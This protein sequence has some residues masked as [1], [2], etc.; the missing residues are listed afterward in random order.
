[1]K[2]E[3]ITVPMAKATEMSAYIN[4]ES[5][6]NF[7]HRLLKY[8]LAI[9]A[10]AGVVFISQLDVFHHDNTDMPGKITNSTTIQPELPILQSKAASGKITCNSVIAPSHDY[11]NYDPIQDLGW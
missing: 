1:M 3:Q 4:S 9:A 7:L 8:A 5:S 11:V 2:P 6:G 10:I